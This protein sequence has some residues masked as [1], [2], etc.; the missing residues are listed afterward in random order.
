MIQHF[1]KL[2]KDAIPYI[3][4][5]QTL[6]IGIDQPLY[7]L[8]K[9]N[10]WARADVYGESSYVE[11]MG[12]LHIEMASLKMDGWIPTWSTL[13]EASKACD[14]FIKCGCKGV[15]GDSASAPRQ[16][17]PALHCAPGMAVAGNSD[18]AR[19]QLPSKTP[20]DTYL[21]FLFSNE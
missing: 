2:V 5:R 16:T 7:A 12:G 17:C 4:P 15:Y 20:Q 19:T 6:I 9:Q 14:E 21:H 13:L 11:M 8:P 18:N 10:Q 1:M 3:N